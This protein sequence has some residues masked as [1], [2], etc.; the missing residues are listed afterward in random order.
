MTRISVTVGTG[1]SHGTGNRDAAVISVM[2]A[3]SDDTGISDDTD[4][5]D[6]TGSSDDRYPSVMTGIHQ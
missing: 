1:I 5:S 3:K 4:I 2:T 6:D